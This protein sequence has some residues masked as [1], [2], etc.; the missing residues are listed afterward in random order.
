[1]RKVTLRMMSV[2]RGGMGVMSDRIWKSTAP[3]RESNSSAGLLRKRSGTC[4]SMA[5]VEC[6]LNVLRLLKVLGQSSALL[7]HTV[8]W[9]ATCCSS[10]RP[11]IMCLAV[12]IVIS[13]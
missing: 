1:V 2:V 5:S 11:S 12:S 8:F 7:F 10:G 13:G 3:V 9:K 6:M 4:R